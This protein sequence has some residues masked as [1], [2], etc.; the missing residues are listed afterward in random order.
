MKFFIW[1][2]KTGEGKIIWWYVFQTETHHP[3][4]WSYADLIQTTDDQ[5]VAFAFMRTAMATT[6]S[7]GQLHYRVNE[8]D[9]WMKNQ[10]QRLDVIDSDIKQSI[11]TINQKMQH[12]INAATKAADQSLITGKALSNLEISLKNHSSN[13]E[14]RFSAHTGEIIRLMSNDTLHDKRIETFESHVRETTELA[15]KAITIQADSAAK[16]LSKKVAIPVSGIAA[17]ATL[18]QWVIQ[19]WP[20]ISKHFH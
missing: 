18:C 3:T 19:N 10:V 8:M 15:V 4:H 11:S 13:M 1:P 5:G 17:L 6:N 12:A 20:W 2:G 16:G 14:D 7:Y 9:T